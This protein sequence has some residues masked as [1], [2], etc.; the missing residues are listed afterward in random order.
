[1]SP[2]GET[3]RHT[4]ADEAARVPQRIAGFHA[5][6]RLFL[7]LKDFANQIGIYRDS[8][9]QPRTYALTGMNWNYG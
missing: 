5:K 9:Q 3:E 1:L 2:P 4:C 7:S 8:L 6:A